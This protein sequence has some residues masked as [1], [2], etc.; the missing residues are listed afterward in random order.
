M[1]A[2]RFHEFPR[3]VS[4]IHR[5]KRRQRDGA[6]KR[7]FALLTDGTMAAFLL[8]QMFAEIRGQASA[9]TG[10]ALEKLTMR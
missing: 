1:F 9:Q 10:V 2:C 3:E 6:L 5:R 8:R 7:C 4:K